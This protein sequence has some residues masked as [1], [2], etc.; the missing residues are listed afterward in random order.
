MKVSDPFGRHHKNLEKNYSSFRQSL[1]DANIDNL[2]KTKQLLD[3]TRKRVLISSLIIIACVG[4]TKLFFPALTPMVF[5]FA[6]LTLIWLFATLLNSRR[7]LI[8]YMEEEFKT[9]PKQT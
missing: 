9:T 2:E 3:I 5:V 8:R 6:G 7:F 1:K 4:V